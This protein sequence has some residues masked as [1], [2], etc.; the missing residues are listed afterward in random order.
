MAVTYRLEIVTPEG[1]FFEGDVAMTVIRT[2][3]GDMGI[4]ADHENTVAPL[5]IG[6]LKIK[7]DEEMRIAACTSG[8][9][10]VTPEGV[11]IVTDS[12]EWA[13]EIDVDRAKEALERARRRLENKH[14]ETDILR[15]QMAMSRAMNRVRVAGKSMDHSDL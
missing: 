13:D 4:L 2:A 3:E 15:A 9:V 1:I 11:T 6:E 8:F 7:Q 12:A 14:K 10:S 5:K